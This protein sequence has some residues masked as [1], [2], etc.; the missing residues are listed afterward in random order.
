[1]IDSWINY[2]PQIDYGIDVN[3]KLYWYFRFVEDYYGI[4]LF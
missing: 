2:Q 3:R 1:V 4:R